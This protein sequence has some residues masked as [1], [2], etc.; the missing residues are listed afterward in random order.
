M[1]IVND[2]TSNIDDHDNYDRVDA[3]SGKKRKQ[4]YEKT[5]NKEINDDHSLAC[6][7]V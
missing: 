2:N 1:T 3:Q 5:N 7:V 6:E 4:M